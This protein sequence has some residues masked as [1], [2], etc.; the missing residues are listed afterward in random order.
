MVSSNAN[1]HI[2]LCSS[3][4]YRDI[5]K[6]HYTMLFGNVALAGMFSCVF[7]FCCRKVLVNYVIQAVCVHVNIA[8]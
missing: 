6:Y 2:M 5:L 8:Q 4:F 1:G 3:C 7:Q